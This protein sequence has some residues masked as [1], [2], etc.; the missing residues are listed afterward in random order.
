MSNTAPLPPPPNPEEFGNYSWK[1]WFIKL[2]DYLI[3]TRDIAETPVD[4]DITEGIRLG[5]LESSFLDLV[6]QIQSVELNTRIASLEAEIS[7]LR[8][9]IE[10]LKQGQ[11]I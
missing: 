8:Q 9:Q 11:M 1:D 2:R 4:P 3:T 7:D 5:V 10:D 6:S